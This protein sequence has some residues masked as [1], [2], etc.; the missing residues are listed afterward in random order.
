MRVL[1]A[2]LLVCIAAC[3]NETTLT[4]IPPSTLQAL[5]QDPLP[6]PPFVYNYTTIAGQSGFEEDVCLGINEAEV[7]ETGDFGGDVYHTV[8]QTTTVRVDGNVLS[9]LKFY[10]LTSSLYHYDT[11]QNLIGSHGGGISVCFDVLNAS[12][13]LHLANLDLRSTSGVPH[14]FSWVFEVP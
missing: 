8:Q 12:P 2:T 9:D 10:Q 5:Q 4:P 14:A 6:R 13:G 1:I 11:N 3:T 7:W